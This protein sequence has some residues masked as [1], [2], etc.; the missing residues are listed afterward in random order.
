MNL[1]VRE[2]YNKMLE[3]KRSN[4]TFLL[5]IDGYGGAGKSTLAQSF[6]E[7]DPDRVTVIHMDDFYKPSNLR[8]LVEE[9]EAGGNWEY[10]R[11][12]EQILIPLINNQNTKYQRYDWD[13]D[14]MAEWHNVPAGGVVIVEGCYALIDGINEYYHFKIWV[15]SPKNIRL[16]RGIERDGEHKRHLWEE[17][18][19]PAEEHYMQTQKPQEKADLIIDGTGEKSNINHLQVHT[20]RVPSSWV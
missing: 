5:G 13:T 4:K 10:D 9:N 12:K 6:K 20:L 7:V 19:M 18:W 11:V 2:L 8:E 15:H 1:S 17:L 14:D 16:A 3:S